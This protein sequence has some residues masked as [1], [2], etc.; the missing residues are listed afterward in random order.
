VLK[1]RLTY[2]WRIIMGQKIMGFGTLK[3]P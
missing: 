2:D 1:Q 3:F